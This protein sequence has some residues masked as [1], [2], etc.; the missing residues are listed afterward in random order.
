MLKNKNIR[1]KYTVTLRNKI[2]ALQEISEAPIANDEFENF[3][4]THLEAAAELISTKQITK[5]RVPWEKLAV[6]KK[7]A[8]VKIASLRNRRIPTNVNIQKPK[9]ALNEL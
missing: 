3:I 7:R 8:D 9:K 2:D 4:N 1:D 6:R 5:R